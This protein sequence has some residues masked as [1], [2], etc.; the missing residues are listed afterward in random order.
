M[1]DALWNAYFLG[2]LLT[3]I[4]SWSHVRFC[5]RV[6]LWPAYWIYLL[7]ILIELALAEEKRRG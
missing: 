4:S 5:Q 7:V 3:A 2:A 6:L 1:A